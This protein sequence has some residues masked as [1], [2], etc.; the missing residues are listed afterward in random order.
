VLVDFATAFHFD[1]VEREELGFVRSWLVP[2][3][4]DGRA[5][6]ERHW[7]PEMKTRSAPCADVA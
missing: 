2:R 4:A 3:D 1:L 7:M 6:L 5:A